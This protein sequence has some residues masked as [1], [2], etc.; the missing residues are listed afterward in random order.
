VSAPDRRDPRDVLGAQRDRV[1]AAVD[2]AEAR[3]TR[4]ALLQE[5]WR[6]LQPG[7]PADR[8][9]SGHRLLSTIDAAIEALD[10]ARGQLV[11]ALRME[12]EDRDSQ[13]AMLVA[14]RFSAEREDPETGVPV[15]ADR[16]GWAPGGPA[17]RK[18]IPL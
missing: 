12:R 11:A 1:A 15:P 6:G 16:A 17:G 4:A 7:T 3:L 14:E 5:T 10:D 18:A 13:V 2:Q 8:V 9:R